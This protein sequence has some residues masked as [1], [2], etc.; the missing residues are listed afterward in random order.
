MILSNFILL[1]AIA[2]IIMS[3]RIKR[4]KLNI[5]WPIKFFKFLLPFFSYAF[6]SQSYLLFISAIICVDNGSFINPYIKCHSIFIFKL[7]IPFA[8]L[9]IVLQVFIGIITNILYF[10]PAFIKTGSDPLKKSNSYHP[11]FR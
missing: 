10:K 5:L 6:F 9:G 2:M 1:L 8:S 3:Y 7:L 4:K 11:F